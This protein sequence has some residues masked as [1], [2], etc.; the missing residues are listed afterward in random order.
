MALQPGTRV[1]GYE[2][3]E[4]LGRGGMGEVYRARDAKLGRDV[5]IKVL[6]EAWL[7]DPDRRSRL[8]R[9][10][11]VLASLNHPHIGAIYG[12]EEAGGVPALV[13]ELVDGQTLA[14]RLLGIDRGRADPPRSEA[15]SAAG[16][17]AGLP[18][19]EALEIAR[20]IADALDA[21]HERGVIHRDL[22]P[23]NIKLTPEGVVKV[24]D[25]GLATY[26][27]GPAFPERVPE[28]ASMAAQA[29]TAI[30]GTIPGTILGTVRYMSP[31]QARGRSVDKR[32]DIWAF[33]G[34]LYEM[35]T[36]RPPFGGETSSDVI[37][38]ILERE[39]PWAALPDAVSRRVRRLLERCLI[40]DPKQRLRDIGDARFEID[41]ALASPDTPPPA[42]SGD[43]AN[44]PTMARWVAVAAGSAV[45]SGAVVWTLTPRVSPATSASWSVS[46]LVISPPPATPLAVDAAQIAVSPDGRSVAYVAGRWGRQ[47]IHIRD[48]NQFNSTPIPGTEGG[49]NPFFSP[50]SRW[51]GFTAAGQLKKV[52]LSGGT[53]QT[54]SDVSAAMTWQ[55]APKWEVD[56]TIFYVPTTGAGIW[57]VAA[58]G[59]TPVAVTTLTGTESSH[60][61]PQLLPGG[62]ALLFSAFTGSDEPQ[63]FVQPLES[64]PRRAVTKGSAATFL[65]SGHVAYVQA[66]TLM[67]VPFDVARLEITGTPVAVLSGIMEMNRLRN[68]A[69][70]NQGPQ[71]S[72]S[73]AGTMAYIPAGKPKQTELVWVDRT[74]LETPSG[75]SG[76][77]YYQPRV[78]PDGQRVA[79]TVRG[80]D[81][82]DVWLYDLAR[83]TWS[84]FTSNGNHAFPLW[85]PDGRTL[86][87]VSDKN[88]IDN[89]YRK[90][91]DGAAAEERLITA[92]RPN[93]PFSWSRDGVLL[94]V[95]VSLSTVQDI[96]TL[97]TGAE[98]KAAPFLET[99]FVEGAPA[100]SP[101]GRWVAY[102]SGES[103]RTEIHVR[104]FTGSGEKLTISTE[105]GNEPVWSRNG[106]ELFYRSGDAMMAVDVTTS[107]VLGA[108]KPRRLFE[109]PYELSYA[110]WPDY[111]V[112][113]DGKRF[114]M[115]KVL[116]SS[117]VPA[118]I[119]VVLDWT[120]ELKRLVRPD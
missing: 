84:R 77:M 60:R 21:A 8:E 35:L 27:Q 65:P 105:G 56:D 98:R 71:V 70:G 43:R 100:L 61:W 40:K 15:E 19:K 94:Y 16:S 37:A 102:A 62:N 50:D 2:I 90:P 5:A 4:L 66:G 38:A 31:E 103:G 6:S 36:G 93:Y 86:T 42:A 46:R 3:L 76:G 41:D 97:R 26:Q 104:P 22:K 10:A 30:V 82:D 11:R 101:D 106:R 29:A 89:M 57:R 92:D 47:Q 116:E 13:L 32:T 63:V 45:L 118:Q 18:L 67:A 55:T 115:V 59:G 109:R 78:S 7:T 14:E 17:K 117:D 44:R 53:P 87:Y 113:P 107:P 91:L 33:G 99:P 119:N 110:L 73:P 111:D 49:N 58:G 23:E 64:G 120:E 74:G 28:S 48:L 68:S 24:L 80:A 81:R 9:E 34:V 39:P 54:I 95:L 75:A 20:Q 52:L 51:L 108:G 88:S 114:L 112:S 25:F 96:W 83:Q 69:L 85:A 79:V 72:F 12:T 1:G